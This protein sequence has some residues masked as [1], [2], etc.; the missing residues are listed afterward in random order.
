[1]SAGLAAAPSITRGWAALTLATALCLTGR[2]VAAQTSA[3]QVAVAPADSAP[4]AV[5]RTAEQLVAAGDSADPFMHP[6]ASLAFY[7]EAIGVDSAFYAAWWKA[8]RA[9]VD[10]GKQ[11]Q[12]NDDLSREHRDS[13][14][15]VARDYATRAI[16]LNQSDAN[17]HYVLAL[18]LGRLSLTRGG[19]DRV[20]FGK[21]IYNESAF[22]VQLS[23]EH[24][25]AHHVVG[26]FHAEVRRL[27]ATTRFI[28]KLLFG[29]RLLKIS[30]WD[31]ATVHLER[32]VALAPANIFHRLELAKVYLD[33][34]R[35]ADAAAQLEVIAGLPDGDVQDPEYR[36][37]AAELLAGI[38]KKR[39]R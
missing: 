24:D 34:D 39:G 16:R 23:P 21:I 18:A 7:R 11:I 6:D 30:S 29:A 9:L 14:Y 15:F 10:V 3:G 31:S 26:A 38:R 32:A 20:R 35:D 4:P 13:L 19:R 17:G 2:T 28:A 5:V 22:A 12:Q 27:P 37:S 33:I 8:G 1:M 36:R 25:G